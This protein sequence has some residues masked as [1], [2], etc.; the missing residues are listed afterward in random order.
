MVI[1]KGEKPADETPS[2]AMVPAPRL[3][4]ASLD[5]KDLARAILARQVR[6][7]VGDV[8]RLAEAALD[9]KRK[10]KKGAKKSDR[11]K[12]KLSKIPGQR[13]AK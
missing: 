13:P 3:D 9:K 7:R 1:S 4:T 8:R 11:K 12:R 6:P 10:S 2:P 5:L